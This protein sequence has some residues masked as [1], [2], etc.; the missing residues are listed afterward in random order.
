M[1][2]ENLN[3]NDPTESQSQLPSIVGP[4]VQSSFSGGNG[5][6]CVMVAVTEN[7]GRAIRHSQDQSQ[8]P[9]TL[10]FSGA[11][12]EAFIKGAQAGEFGQY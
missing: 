10:Y 6:A 3:G 4:W 9:T 5:G 1:S 8:E 2:S 11:E 7:E 12:W